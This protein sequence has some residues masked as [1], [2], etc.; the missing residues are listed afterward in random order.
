M[1]QQA[2]QDIWH[3]SHPGV[4]VD[5][6]QL[7]TSFTDGESEAPEENHNALIRKPLHDFQKN[8]TQSVGMGILMRLFINGFTS[9]K[10][11]IEKKKS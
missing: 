9:N 10:T 6:R 7:K 2:F 3:S 1:L 8:H 4:L 5:L 11:I